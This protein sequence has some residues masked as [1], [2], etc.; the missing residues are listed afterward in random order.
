MIRHGL[1]NQRCFS[2]R[3]KNHPR[4]RQTQNQERRRIQP[5][6]ANE[7]YPVAARA[8]H[9]CPLLDPGSQF[10]R[11]LVV[12]SICLEEADELPLLSERCPAVRAPAQMLFQFEPLSSL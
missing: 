11:R 10:S 6:L 1:N 5:R 7:E 2:I 3:R 12:R 4:Q 8:F 9:L